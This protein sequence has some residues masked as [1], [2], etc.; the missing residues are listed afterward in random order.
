M[1]WLF[2]KKNDEKNTEITH[3]NNLFKRSKVINSGNSGACEELFLHKHY[4]AEC[5]HA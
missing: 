4:L 1:M 2:N 5:K 3:H